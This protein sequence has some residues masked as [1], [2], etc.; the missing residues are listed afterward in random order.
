MQKFI[1]GIKVNLEI[2]LFVL[3]IL[4][5]QTANLTDWEEELSYQ[6]LIRVPTEIQEHNSMI[7]P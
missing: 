5:V 1:S 6:I 7:F 2:L 3:S 4:S